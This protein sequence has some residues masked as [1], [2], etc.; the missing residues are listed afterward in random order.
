MQRDEERSEK[1]KIGL[2][3]ISEKRA[4]GRPWRMRFSEIAG[5]SEHFRGILNQVWERLWPLLSTASTTEEV[6]ESFEKGASPYERNFTP[7][8]A[9]LTLR[10]IR[11][12]LFP[13]RG[14]S[15]ANFLAD[16]LAGLGVIVPRR[17]RD[18]CA[19]E[20]ARVKKEHHILRYEFYVEC[21]CGY[22]G[23]S[24]NHAC[25]KCGAKI[26]YFLH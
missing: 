1:E 6:V 10:V 5:R 21:S 3:T 26:E 16:S 20:R 12:P 14:R 22:N 7:H 23:P 8:L 25:Q 9:E 15:Q 4:R 11:E 18:I 13:K 19:G 24:R 17:S 2:D